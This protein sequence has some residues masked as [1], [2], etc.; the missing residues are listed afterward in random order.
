MNENKKTKYTVKLVIEGPRNFET[1]LNEEPL[2]QVNL[3]HFVLL[4]HTCFN[5]TKD[6]YQD[7]LKNVVQG[8]LEVIELTKREVAI[9]SY[10]VNV[11]EGVIRFAE[12]WET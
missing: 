6:F 11:F 2:I 3:E 12:H 1:T 9:F 4:L 7:Y 5:D 8:E 10:L